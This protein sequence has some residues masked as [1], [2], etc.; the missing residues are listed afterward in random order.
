MDSLLHVSQPQ[1]S[2]D[3]TFYLFSVALMELANLTADAAKVADC[4]P[5]ALHGYAT[6]GM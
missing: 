5:R 6:G 3:S 4:I 1:S 2:C